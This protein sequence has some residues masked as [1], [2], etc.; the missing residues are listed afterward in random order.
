MVRDSMPCVICKEKLDPL[1]STNCD[2]CGEDVCYGCSSTA[3]DGR[4]L[5]NDCRAAL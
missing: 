4:T 5:C 1:E 3:G 2:E